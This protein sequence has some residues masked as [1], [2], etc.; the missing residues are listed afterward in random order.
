M[1][2]DKQ[3]MKFR[4]KG[5][6]EAINEKLKYIPLDD[7]VTSIFVWS[8]E[9]QMQELIK[10]YESKLIECKMNYEKFKNN[11][12]SFYLE[13]AK[14]IQKNKLYHKFFEFRNFIYCELEQK[15]V[16]S[17]IARAYFDLLIQQKCYFKPLK[18]V[19]GVK[20]NGALMYVDE[21]YPYIDVPFME[22]DR[23]DREGRIEEFEDYAMKQFKSYGVNVKHIREVELLS[24]HERVITNMIE[25]L[26]YYIDEDYK[27]LLPIPYCDTIHEISMPRDIWND[28]DCK[29]LK[30]KLKYRRYILP[31]KGVTAKLKNC[32][33]IAEILFREK[34]IGNNIILLFKIKLLD[35]TYSSGFYDIIKDVGSTMWHDSSQAKDHDYI[36]NL[37]LM[38]YVLLVTELRGNH[39]E[40]DNFIVV[41]DDIEKVDLF[42]RKIF[43]Q[44]DVLIKNNKGKTERVKSGWKL[45]KDEYSV[46]PKSMGLSTRKLPVG[47]NASE[48]AIARAKE[49]G[50]TLAEGET[51]VRAFEKKVYKKNEK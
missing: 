41:V 10:M 6:I 37:I 21:L 2:K 26:A 19:Y 23:F 35:G 12:H 33:D 39:E 14:Y 51:F 47:W 48:E 50:I 43:V 38:N 24:L 32:N 45:N 7:L 49:I 11:L 44:Y 30:D 18:I 36:M 42:S 28:F 20:K 17:P 25:N 9:K 13:T 29:T 46:I 8:E 3:I 16:S 34:F 1:L 22:I 31:N 15:R 5:T 40:L 4:T 27:E